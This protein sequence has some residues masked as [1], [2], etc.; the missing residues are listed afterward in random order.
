MTVR[1]IL[2]TKGSEV[3]TIEP[4]KKLADA[5][6]VLAERKIGALVV[7]GADRRVVGIVSERDIVQDLA[8]HGPQSLDLPLT[9]VMTRKVVTCSEA[10]TVSSVMERMTAG[11]F[12]HLPVVDQGRLVGIISI[13]DV[14]KY[15]LHEMEREQSAMRDYIQTA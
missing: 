7:T 5:A 4:T 2:K 9:D 12:R 14:V 13:G 1:A 8:A 10:D 6:R 15:R 3:L 11:K